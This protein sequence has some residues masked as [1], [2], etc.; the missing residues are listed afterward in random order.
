[1]SIKFANNIKT[2]L[3]S[4]ISPLQTVFSVGSSL[5]FPVLAAGDYFYATLLNA[6]YTSGDPIE[7]IRV[8]NVSGNKLT[9]ERGVDGTA[10]SSWS[11]GSSFEL[12]IPRIA[13]EDILLRATT[14][15]RETFTA[16]QD[17]TVFTL[18]SSQYTLGGN[19]LNVYVNGSKQILG[20]NYVETDT[21]S[22]TFT[23]GLNLND[24][25][26]LTIGT[27]YSTSELE[28]TIATSVKIGRAHV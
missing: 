23:A 5:G 26:E 4:G 27:T 10:A 25:V 2:T 22:I 18:A 8:T 20:V 13:L 15:Y 11:A 12:R 17:Q 3:A 28:S 21:T 6:G 7:V 9:V 19:N 14:Q 16:T 1:M 24:A